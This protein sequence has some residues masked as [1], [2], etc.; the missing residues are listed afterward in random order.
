MNPKEP[1]AADSL[2]H[3][4]LD[5]GGRVLLPV[6]HNQLIADVEMEVV[7]L[8]PRC[9][10]S[11]LL[12]VGRL[13]VGGDQADGGLVVSRLDGGVGAVGGLTV[14]REQGVQEWA[15]HATLRGAGVESGWRM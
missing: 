11:D 6:V 13:I 1:E 5:G 3:S 7:V 2:Y 15:E 10:G 12:S 4:P 9:Q 14:I 8:A